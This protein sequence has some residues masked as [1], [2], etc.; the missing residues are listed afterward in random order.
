MQK[1]APLKNGKNVHESD[2]LF[3]ELDGLEWLQR[4]TAR[5]S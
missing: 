4:Q 1:K 2:M 5:H 3:A